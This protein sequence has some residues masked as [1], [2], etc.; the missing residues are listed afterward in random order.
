[1]VSSLKDPILKTKKQ[2]TATKKGLVVSQGVGPEFKP[3]Y[4]KKNPQKTKKN[5]A[6]LYSHTY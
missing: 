6:L 3:Q 1:M 4:C 2:K 5:I